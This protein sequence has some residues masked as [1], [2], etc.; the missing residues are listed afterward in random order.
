MERCNFFLE[1]YASLPA[2]PYKGKEDADTLLR[3]QAYGGME[4]IVGQEWQQQRNGEYKKR[5]DM[6]LE[7]IKNT[8]FSDYF[9]IVG[10]FVKWAKKQGI[11]VG[12]GR[13]SGAGS[14]VAYAISITGVDPL[15]H[16]LFFERFLN[17][18]RAAMP[19]FDIDICMERRDEVI[20]YI[21]TTY[22]EE[23][24]VQIISFG[25]MGAR[26]V[27]RDVTRALG[28]PFGLGDKLARLIPEMTN[29]RGALSEHPAVKE[30]I[31]QD[32]EA[33]TVYHQAMR[34]E[35]VVRHTSSHAAGLVITPQLIKNYCPLYAEGRTLLTQFDK[36]DLETMGLVKFDVLGLR[37]L[38]V[39]DQALLLIQQHEKKDID[40][41]GIPLDDEKT[42]TLVR[43]AHTYGV[44]Q[45]ESS[46]M[47]DVARR[48]EPQSFEDII[49]L[50]A[51]FRPGPMELI[52]KFIANKKMI[53]S[54]KE[55][56]YPHSSL[57]EILRPTY[58]IAI[59][60]EQ[61]MQMAQIIAGFS[62]A[63][64]DVLRHAMGK[65]KIDIMLQQKQ[66]FIQGAVQ[67]GYEQEKAAELFTTIEKFAGYGFNRSH[68]VGY[69][70]LAYW[71]AY[72][73]AHHPYAF[74]AASMSSEGHN[75]KKLVRLVEECHR[76]QLEVLPPDINKSLV[77]FSLDGKSI[78]YGLASIKG[79]GKRAAGIIVAARQKGAFSGF[80]AF[81][82]RIE[83]RIL[84][85]G[86][87]ESLIRAGAFHNLETNQA[88]LIENIERGVQH[89]KNTMLAAD[90]GVS[91][92]FGNT[93]KK[94]IFKD[95]PAPWDPTRALRE[96]K[97]AL[98]FALRGD[99]FKIHQKELRLYIPTPLNSIPKKRGVIVGG[100]VR[101]YKNIVRQG[102]KDIL[103]FS[104]YDD[105]GH[106]DV[107]VEPSCYLNKEE[108]VREDNI[109]IV[110][111]DMKEYKNMRYLQAKTIYGMEHFRT[112]N[113]KGLCLATDIAGLPHKKLAL[114][115]E[116]L[117]LYT[118]AKGLPFYL[119]IRTPKI[120]YMVRFLKKNRIV[121]S[122]ECFEALREKFP[123]SKI[124]LF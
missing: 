66:Q 80:F 61:I 53:E 37:T 36:D 29:L 118:N 14:L 60:Q 84:T 95:I 33:H 47:R 110:Q 100:R 40:M 101:H 5:V 79:I 120:S 106:I 45:L 20:N 94:E 32:R 17:P 123:A 63:Q 89:N 112:I 103:A 30:L 55:I 9:L 3:Q 50:I 41:H 39:I 72:L 90:T 31:E 102:E 22:G 85:R 6:E 35:G 69:A 77:E 117:S 24:A 88:L 105:T 92:M 108:L 99:S 74:L 25:T 11:A 27:I 7:I 34:I 71:T 111:G 42:L 91:D 2:Y 73:K 12:P 76:F 65:K 23:C 75:H 62:L 83:S 115:K 58:G 44:F 78:R 10:D 81:C 21:R 13:G 97:I 98:G 18:G 119:K 43:H 68:S 38:T 26:G 122:N 51:L 124:R 113:H 121:P 87:L 96:E 48:I 54:N 64:A 59:Y 56:A 109:L 114:L 107:R 67:Q 1:P 28:K 82:E 49:A 46:G 16:N 4:E 57:K 86:L 93:V 15:V 116:E 104:L 70:L 52:D 19:D 8:G